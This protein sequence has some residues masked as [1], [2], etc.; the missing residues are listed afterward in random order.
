[1][2]I[3]TWYFNNLK[4]NFH[5]ILYLAKTKQESYFIFNNLT[6]RLAFLYQIQHLLKNI[7]ISKVFNQ[8]SQSH[9]Y[10]IILYFGF[11][12]LSLDLNKL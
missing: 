7:F 12:L 4:Q 2:Q 10:I 9:A 3:N 5:Q 1:M 11:M 6:C 8:I